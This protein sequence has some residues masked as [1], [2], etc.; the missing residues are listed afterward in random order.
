MA[1]LYCPEASLRN[2]GGGGSCFVL[3]SVKSRTVSSTASCAVSSKDSFLS[4]LYN[5]EQRLFLGLKA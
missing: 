3:E 2:G 5:G 1:V 4:N